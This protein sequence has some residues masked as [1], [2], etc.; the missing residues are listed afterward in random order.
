MGLITN[1]TKIN[2][3]FKTIMKNCL[4]PA[5]P[6][7]KSLSLLSVHFTNQT[8]VSDECVPLEL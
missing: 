7:G 2:A 1:E 5:Y 8:L 3:A 6:S 4:K